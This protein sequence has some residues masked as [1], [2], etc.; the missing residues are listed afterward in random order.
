MSGLPSDDADGTINST[1]TWPRLAYEDLVDYLIYRKA[2]DG[3]EMK[4]CRSLYAKNY[5]ESGW[6]GDI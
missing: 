6:L 5:V 2:Y 1:K 3:K 4:A